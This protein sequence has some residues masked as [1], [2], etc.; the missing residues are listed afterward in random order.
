MIQTPL[1]HSGKPTPQ[2]VWLDSQ[3]QQ[4]FIN[5]ER[6]YSDIPWMPLAIEKILPKDIEHFVDYF[7]KNSI[8][9]LR[10][11]E[12]FDEYADKNDNQS[13]WHNPYWRTLEIY[14]SPLAKQ[15]FGTNTIANH[16]V[17]ATKIFPELYEQVFEL[18]PYKE[19]FFIRFWSNTRPVDLHRDQDW[20]Y[21]LPL[22][23]R[24]IIYD[25]NSDP[26]FYVAK[27]KGN[28]T[29][30]DY[31]I[32]PD[33]TNSFAF[34]NGAFLHGADHKGKSKI[35]MVVSGIPDINKY[36]KL[37]KS[38]VNKYNP[39]KVYNNQERY[40]VYNVTHKK[41]LIEQTHSEQDVKDLYTLLLTAPE[42]LA[43]EEHQS[44]DQLRSELRVV[45]W[46]QNSYYDF[47]KRT[48]EQYQN[49]IDR[50]QKN[51]LDK[52]VDFYRYTSSDGYTS[53]F[54]ET[55]YPD[56]NVLIDWVF[57][58]YFAYWFV[59][60]IVPLGKVQQ[61]IG[62]GKFKNV[63]IDGARYFK[64]RTSDIVR[65]DPSQKSM[66]DF[67]DLLTYDFE[68]ALQFAIGKE[69]F[70]YH[71]LTKLSHQVE[72]MAQEYIYDCEHSAVLVGHNSLG[73][74]INVHTHRF[75]DVKKYTITFI[76]RLTFFDKPVTYSFY[77]PISETDPLFSRYYTNPN[78]LNSYVENIEPCTI[79][80]HARSSVL[81]FN[82]AYTPHSVT[83]S[84]D[85]Y[86]Y[87]VYDNVTLK[88]GVLEK[89]Q[90]QA[91]K[92]FFDSKSPEDRLFFWDL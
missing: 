65:L 28:D 40:T 20:T 46:N 34:N 92:T 12:S 39:K 29:K 2:T 17:D 6:E 62:Q 44:F 9:G 81:I 33:D 53:E 63:G 15:W 54:L 58:P 50:L 30:L 47:S 18:F 66:K 64:K 1:D 38:S 68:H 71:R 25:E 37:L 88:E 16:N 61:Y 51:Y 32:L 26:T 48:S 10:Q 84:N 52:S 5:L 69:P 7:K 24:S 45:F 43:V 79:Q 80:T 13:S 42:V 74:Q 22:S 56:A 35:L 77:D 55:T 14:R 86:L 4:Q 21:N 27:N 36:N 59:I 11:I 87:Y 83:Y 3:T 91:Q 72:Q 73:K 49:M 57:I 8:P 89:I 41:E 19:I 31:V 70:I 60:N 75:S 78:L 82:A 90:I 85:L 23:C 67:P 76:V